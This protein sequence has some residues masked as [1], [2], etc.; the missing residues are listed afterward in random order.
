M[1]CDTTANQIHVMCAVRVCVC[2][3][4]VVLCFVLH[5]V[6]VFL[7]CCVYCVCL[8]TISAFVF[9]YAG[10]VVWCHVWGLRVFVQPEGTL[11]RPSLFGPP[12]KR[13]CGPRQKVPRRFF[14]KETH[15]GG[16]HHFGGKQSTR[17]A[18]STGKAGSPTHLAPL[19]C[20]ASR[21]G[22]SM[23]RWP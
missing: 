22:A 5:C 18:C 8:T 11:W 15:Q 3:F 19:S 10:F 13:L 7:S 20:P 12:S 23:G 2:V 21:R 9:V 14:L 17:A 1:A 4:L 16:F 6:V